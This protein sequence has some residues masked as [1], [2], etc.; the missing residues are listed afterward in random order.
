MGKAE[1]GVY[2]RGRRGGKYAPLGILGSIFGGIG[3]DDSA[4][5]ESGRGLGKI[6]GLLEADGA[7]GG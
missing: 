4:G 5:R 2:G 6:E 7:L 1:L 3:R